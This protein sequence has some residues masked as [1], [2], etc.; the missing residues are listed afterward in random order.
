L[1]KN[2]SQQTLYSCN[3]LLLYLEQGSKKMTAQV[4]K[5]HKNLN[6]K[7]ELVCLLV[8]IKILAFWQIFL[9]KYYY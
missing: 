8:N 7:D 6:R 1:T 5:K 2:V 4:Y 3:S 9:N